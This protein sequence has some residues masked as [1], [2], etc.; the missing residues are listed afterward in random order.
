MRSATRST[1]AAAS[2]RRDRRILVSTQHRDG[3]DSE[4]LIK[5][6]YQH[7]LTA[8]R[9]TSTTEAAA[10]KDVVT[11]PTESSYRRRGRHRPTGRKIIVYTYAAQHRTVGAPLGKSRP[12]STVGR[13]AARY[14]RKRRAAGLADRCQIQ[15]AYAIGVAPRSPSSS[16]VRHHA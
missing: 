1:S 7:V 16:T 2:G 13:Y 15:V 10:Q 4:A 9:P 5:P 8:C 14:V 3:L 11:H 6:N 12:M